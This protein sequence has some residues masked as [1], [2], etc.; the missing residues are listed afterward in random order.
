MARWSEKQQ[1]TK[2]QLIR[3]LE[4][5]RNRTLEEVDT[6]GVLTS[7]K[8]NKGYAGAV[9][10]QSVLG[11][12]PDT[13]R[14][15]DLLVDGIP[16]ELKTTGMI[17]TS[18]GGKRHYEAKE[19]VSVTAVQPETIDG[20]EFETSAFYEK[21]AHILF[22]YYFYAHR[23]ST[24]AEYGD[25]PIKGYQF[26]DL[27]DEE[28]EAV[29]RDW[30]IVRDYIRNIKELHPDNPEKYYPGISSD[31]NRQRL[32]VLDTAP[33]WPNR[34]RFRLKRGFVSQF[35]AQTFGSGF[36]MLPQRYA[37]L[38]E[39]DERC[40]E[41]RSIWTG[42]TVGELAQA[43]GMDA[44]R[45]IS[46]AVS[47][48]VIVRMFGGSGGKLS[49]IADFGRLSIDAHTFVVTNKGMR[50]EDMKINPMIDFDTF[51]DPDATFADSAFRAMFS[52]P[53]VLVA[54][55]EEPSTD[56]PLAENRFLGF[57]RF[58]YPEEFIETEVK[59]CW[60]EA[61]ATVF[62]GQLRD[63]P[64]IDKATGRPRVNRNGRIVAAPNWPKS[65]DHIVFF[66]GSATT[67]EDRPL[68]ICGIRMYRQ[69]VWVKGSYFARLVSEAPFL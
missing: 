33:K 24:P 41:L 17:E 35:V 30:E 14:R 58:I 19:P 64:V 20:E 22:V 7:G 45:K 29:R 40:H 49:R 9:V 2:E 28:L 25:F 34:P 42:K 51:L 52:E 4:R 66:R 26:K 43:F 21:V 6:A 61:R 13:A 37:G 1:F 38:S 63:V 68:E 32:S 23:C 56:A 15:P 67:T 5:A 11:Y 39:L 12:P 16:V 10:E 59:S 57:K 3:L 44:G 48:R 54:L 62:S 53:Q 27:V 46:K 8:R 18:T 65:R 31:L 47:E 36:E 50:T 60:D 55:F 69:N